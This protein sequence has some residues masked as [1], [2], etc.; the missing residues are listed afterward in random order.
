MKPLAATLRLPG[1]AE[2]LDA[3]KAFEDWCARRWEIVKQ[4]RRAPG[5]DDHEVPLTVE[6]AVTQLL[7]KFMRP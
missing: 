2:A 3:M 5:E 4:Y 6:R 1:A 7:E